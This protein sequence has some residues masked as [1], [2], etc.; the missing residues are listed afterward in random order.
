MTD[1]FAELE[2][3]LKQLRPQPISVKLRTRLDARLRPARFSSTR[4]RRVQKLSIAIGSMAVAACVAAAAIWH[5][6]RQTDTPEH[7]LVS[8]PASN[9]GAQ[10]P[11][12]EPTRFAY[13][14]AFAL[15]AEAFDLLLDR[16]AVQSA[17]PSPQPKRA[18]DLTFF[19]SHDLQLD[20]RGDL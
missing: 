7:T 11:A 17:S 20:S 4:L 13:Q 6:T 15:S 3:D 12:T 16:Q 8:S 10:G 18:G 9:S 5:T 14:Q 1:P 2:R 19:R